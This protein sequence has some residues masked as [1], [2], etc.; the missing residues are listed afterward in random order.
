MCVTNLEPQI[1]KVCFYACRRS[2]LSES[3][4][5]NIMAHVPFGVIKC[6]MLENIQIVVQNL[7][8]PKWKISNIS[9]G[10]YK[11]VPPS[12]KLVYKPH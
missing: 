9:N 6:G 12:Y 10:V 4:K 1:W 5:E 7:V 11:V 2:E 8:V 3:G